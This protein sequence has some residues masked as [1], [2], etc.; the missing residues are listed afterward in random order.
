MPWLTSPQLQDQALESGKTVQNFPFPFHVSYFHDVSVSIAYHYA[1]FLDSWLPIPSLWTWLPIITFLKEN[2]TV[3]CTNFSHWSS[4]QGLRVKGGISSGLIE[5]K[6][7]ALPRAKTEH[8]N[9]CCL[10][11]VTSYCSSPL[12][13]KITQP[14]KVRRIC[15]VLTPDHLL[16]LRQF[17]PKTKLIN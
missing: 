1:W 5:V 10:L 17:F 16:N 8:K 15:S 3:H 12:A 13:V 9:Q 2:S 6:S 14:S 4:E 7:I 11:R